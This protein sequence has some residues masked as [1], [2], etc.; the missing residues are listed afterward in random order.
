VQRVAQDW[1]VGA[2]ASAY[3]DR[4]EKEDWLVV[5]W[6]RKA[7]FRQLFDRLNTQTLVELACGH[8]RHTARIFDNH[9]IFTK[10]ER[11]YLMDVNNE[12]V[13]VCKERFK[14]NKSIIPLVN[15]GYN[16]QPLDDESV[17][18]IFCYDA[19]VHF[20]Y[21][22]VVS[23]I[24]DASRILIPGGRALLHHSNYDKSPGADYSSNPG[25]RNFMSKNLFAH[26]AIRAGFKI[27]EQ[28]VIDWD[29]YRTL[30]CISL[31]EKREERD[32]ITSIPYKR[33]R[34][35]GRVLHKLVLRQIRNRLSLNPLIFQNA[36]CRAF[37]ARRRGARPLRRGRGR[38]GRGGA[39]KTG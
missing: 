3:Y 31:I 2:R 9:Q 35:S 27:V 8:G 38:K 4:A 20:E 26:V 22:A 25:W 33:S 37:L 16:F 15:N 10:I 24:D 34:L 1:R 5:F 32:Q 36:E 23:Y 29:D 21:D 39:L 28:L 18:A 7:K 11:M 30:D 12:N 14:N 6:E 19:M 17:T 13:T